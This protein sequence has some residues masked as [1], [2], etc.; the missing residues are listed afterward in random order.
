MSAVEDLRIELDD[1][2]KELHGLWGGILQPLKHDGVV[3]VLVGRVDR[4]FNNTSQDDALRASIRMHEGIDYAT[5]A[6]EGF[7]H[8]E[9]LIQQYIRN[10]L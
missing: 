5:K 8:A 3:N 4:A 1:I 2:A 9:I 10:Y 6:I 7:G